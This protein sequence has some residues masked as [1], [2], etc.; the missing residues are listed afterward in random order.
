MDFSDMGNNTNLDKGRSFLKHLSDADIEKTI[1]LFTS[2]GAV[3]GAMYLIYRGLAEAGHIESVTT[4][5]LE[6]EQCE[7]V[8]TT[9][10]IIK[11]MMY[12]SFIMGAEAAKSVQTLDSLWNRPDAKVDDAFDAIGEE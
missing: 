8:L 5:S 11:Y 4:S 3:D 1:E 6:S 10:H 12:N 2:D 9:V 7:K